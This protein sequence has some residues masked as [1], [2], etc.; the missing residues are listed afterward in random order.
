MA[1][2]RC[3]LSDR[4]ARAARRWMVECSCEWRSIPFRLRR[5]A[6]RASVGHKATESRVA[7]TMPRAVTPLGE[8]PEALR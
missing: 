4:G 8:L 6:R 7:A 1:E 3:H 5:S 2:H